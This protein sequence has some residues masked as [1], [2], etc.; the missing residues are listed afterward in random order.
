MLRVMDR[1]LLGWSTMYT[2]DGIGDRVREL[3]AA[4]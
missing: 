4:M 2:L 1:N 3:I